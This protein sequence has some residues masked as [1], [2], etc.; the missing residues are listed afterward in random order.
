MK[1]KLPLITL[2]VGLLTPSL[3][4]QS[5]TLNGTVPELRKLLGESTERVKLS[6]MESHEAQADQLVVSATV[7]TESKTLAEAIAANRKSRQQLNTALAAHGV[8]GTNLV[9]KPFSFSTEKS[10]FGRKVRSYSVSSRM[11]ITVRSESEFS[12]VIRTLESRNESWKLDSFAVRDSAA[13]ANREKA[14]RKTIAEI[15]RRQAL[16]ESEFG[17]EL[18]AVAFS[19]DIRHG[20]HRYSGVVSAVPTVS[21]S[22]SR[23]LRSEPETESFNDSF[24][25][26]SYPAAMTV[27]FNV[28]RT[29]P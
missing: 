13:A 17:V 26:V 10:F 15:K 4:A 25:E 27:E 21:Y 5:Y 18:T 6:A 3:P 29:K 14:Q 12:D 22:T 2:G 9:Y 28:K 11:Q 20:R 7:R 24:G 1:T 23:V 16:Y 19:E 8:G